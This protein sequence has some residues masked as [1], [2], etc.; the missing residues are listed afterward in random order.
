VGNKGESLS[1]EICDTLGPV[2]TKN[3]IKV[4]CARLELMLHQRW[5]DKFWFAKKQTFFVIKMEENDANAEIRALI[6]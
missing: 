6:I 3:G 2:F 4:D 5:Y 1:T